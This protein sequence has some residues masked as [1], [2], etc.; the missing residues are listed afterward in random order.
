MR[1]VDGASGDIRVED[2]VNAIAFAFGMPLC[3]VNANA[4]GIAKVP[5]T[6]STDSAGTTKSKVNAIHANADLVQRVTNEPLYRQICWNSI[7]LRSIWPISGENRALSVSSASSGRPWYL[8]HKNGIN[9]G[10]LGCHGF[11]ALGRP[12]SHDGGSCRG[13]LVDTALHLGRRG[14]FIGR[15]VHRCSARHKQTSGAP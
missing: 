7:Q 14:T 15:S 1:W 10:C 6:K 8:S 4:R 5:T 2:Q 13:A 9:H 11:S 12:R 3:A